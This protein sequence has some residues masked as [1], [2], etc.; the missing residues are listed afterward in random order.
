MG[1]SSR[2]QP[3]NQ[4]SLGVF[5]FLQQTGKVCTKTAAPYLFS[6]QN[7]SIHSKLS[8]IHL[9]TM[10]LSPP[11]QDREEREVLKEDVFEECAKFG[12]VRDLKMP[13][14]NNVRASVSQAAPRLVR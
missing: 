12:T 3:K 6:N 8:A 11:A 1:S 10:P 14:Q 13:T 5:V 4:R 9:L 7:R 2:L